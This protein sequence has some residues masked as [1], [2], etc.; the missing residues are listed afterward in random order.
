MKW[1][2]TLNEGAD[3]SYRENAQ[4]AVISCLKNTRLL[5]NCVWDG[6]ANDFTRWLQDRG[7]VLHFAKIPFLSQM[8]RSEGM[9]GLRTSAARGAYLRTMIPSLEIADDHVLY[10]DS[11]VVFQKDPVPHL[12][13]LNPEFIA[14]STEAIRGNF[15]YF[16]SGVMLLNIKNLRQ[17][18]N[19]F[20]NF[21][22][23]HLPNWIS[24]SAND[25][26]AINNFFRGNIDR[27]SENYNW[28]PYWGINDKAYIIHFH[29]ARP[30]E[31]IEAINGF[32][33]AGVGRHIDTVE[34]LTAARYYATNYTDYVA[35]SGLPKSRIIS[36]ELFG[37]MLKL[38]WTR[39][40]EHGLQRG[41][42]I[43]IRFNGEEISPV[44]IKAPL[45]SAGQPIVAC[46]LPEFVEHGRGHHV[47]AWIDFFYASSFYSTIPTPA[48]LLEDTWQGV[49]IGA[50]DPLTRRCLAEAR[51]GLV[52]DADALKPRYVVIKASRANLGCPDDGSRA[53]Q[54]S[55]L[56]TVPLGRLTVYTHELGY[57]VPELGLFLDKSQFCDIISYKRWYRSKK[58]LPNSISEIKVDGQIL[59]AKFNVA[60]LVD[61]GERL[62]VGS[63]IGLSPGSKIDAWLIPT[64]VKIAALEKSHSETTKY[65]CEPLQEWQ[66]DILRFIGVFDR[67]VEL[68]QDTSINQQVSEVTLVSGEGTTPE[69][70]NNVW[71]QW[72]EENIDMNKDLDSNLVVLMDSQ[73]AVNNFY[74]EVIRKLESLGFIVIEANHDSIM[75]T[76]SAVS[77]ASL[78][79]VFGGIFDSI[80]A[81]ANSSSSIIEFSNENHIKNSTAYKI[82]RVRKLSYSILMTN[83]TLASAVIDQRRT[84]I[85]EICK[86]VE[87]SLLSNVKTADCG[88]AFRTQ[89]DQRI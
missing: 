66:K 46:L 64:L 21:I 77:R 13:K 2:F 68:S 23:D 87:Y 78:I 12:K 31:I 62:S 19:N 26:G 38:A 39:G 47:E 35:S 50:H 73:A 27:L 82:S 14:A 32:R 86:C 63:F 8:E 67:V 60:P 61:N 79:M 43:R 3:L 54:E 53:V 49:A 40:A 18:H 58:P 84:V 28:K 85:D 52:V 33:E 74:D 24:F 41:L 37:R 30:H 1:Y 51:V 16:N 69:L 76:I 56:P 57:L 10:T 34:K 42:N 65:I 15:D 44:T 80:I 45:A 55:E 83:P 9:R 72:L 70:A 17:T 25:Q 48:V 22:A 7:V 71:V 89:R 6:G 4:A 20:M 11:D 29:S 81:F 36:I 59:T 88:V 5:P 75:T